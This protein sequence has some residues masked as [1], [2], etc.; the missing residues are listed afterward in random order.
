M[1]KVEV[2]TFE[3]ACDGWL[4]DGRKCIETRRLEAPSAAAADESIRQRA[5]FSV[6]DPWTWD[7]RGWLCPRDHRKP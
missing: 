7:Y 5:R 4:T 3:Y 1:G 6:E 2:H